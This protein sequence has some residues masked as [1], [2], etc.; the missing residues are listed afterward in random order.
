M[1]RGCLIAGAACGLGLMIGGSAHAGAAAKGD[2]IAMPALPLIDGGR[3]EPAEWKDRAAVIVFWATDC[4]YCKRHNARLDKL[5]QAIGARRS[6]L[7]IVGIATDG[8]LQAVRR[9]VADH[10]LHFP[11]A[12]EPPGLR[13][14]LTDRRVIPTTILLDRQGRLLFAIPGEM[15][16]EDLLAVGR[17]LG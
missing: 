3:I 17:Q 15:S 14:M 10:G 16:E 9:H 7:L 6:D 4:A 12:L 8:D 1:R 5:Y 13:S 11:V 2:V